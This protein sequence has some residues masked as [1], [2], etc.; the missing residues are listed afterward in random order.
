MVGATARGSIAGLAAVTVI[1]PFTYRLVLHWA[2]LLGWF[3][4]LGGRRSWG[5]QHRFGISD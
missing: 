1:E 4:F 3:A 2:A 5:S